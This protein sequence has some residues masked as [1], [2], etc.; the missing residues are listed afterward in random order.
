MMNVALGVLLWYVITKFGVIANLYFTYFAIS[1]I[2]CLLIPFGSNN[3]LANQNHL[4]LNY[5]IKGSYIIV[6]IS[7][8]FSFQFLLSLPF[9]VALTFTLFLER[10]LLSYY[11]KIGNADLFYIRIVLGRLLSLISV[12]YF[13]YTGN[14]SLHMIII[15]EIFAR[16]IAVPW[17]VG[18]QIPNFQWTNTVGSFIGGV[19]IW[20]PVIWH[21]D[22]DPQDLFIARLVISIQGLASVF[23]LSRPALEA[24]S[25]MQG[26]SGLIKDHHQLLLLLTVLSATPVLGVIL[27]TLGVISFAPPSYIIIYMSFCLWLF[28]WHG[29][30]IIRNHSNK[31]EFKLNF[32]ML[33]TLI[34]ILLIPIQV[35]FK[36]F[37]MTTFWHIY[38]FII[39]VHSKYRREEE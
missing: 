28:S 16:M 25:V 34:P 11:I 35:Q 13:S 21:G 19:C 37:I 2:A 14:I 33:L 32:A 8:L 20:S 6:F 10:L 18:V 26:K 27:A 39:Y 29:A 17:R 9:I 36:V 12:L 24:V 23:Y 4:K 3:H 22:S 30:L 31:R 5:L 1:S 7:I 38:V 15:A